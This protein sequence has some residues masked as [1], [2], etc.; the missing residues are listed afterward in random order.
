MQITQENSGVIFNIQKCF[1]FLCLFVLF[2]AFVYPLQI[3]A[4][5]LPA[6]GTIVAGEATINYADRTMNVNQATEKA[7]IHWDTFN[8][9]SSN[10]VNFNQ[11]SSSSVILNQVLQTNPSN[12]QGTINANGIVILINPAGILFGKNSK[13]NVGG[14]IA[15]TMSMESYEEF[16]KGKYSFSRNGSTGKIVNEGT[17]TAT[18]RGMIALLAP[19]VR[20]E[21]IIRANMGLMI[22]GEKV[23]FDF[24]GDELIKVAVDPSTVSALVENKGLVESPG[25]KVYMLASAKTKLVGEVINSGPIVTADSIRKVGGK[26]YLEASHSVHSSKPINA[27]NASGEAV[28]IKSGKSINIERESDVYTT[29]AINFEVNGDNTS[30]ITIGRD[31]TVASTLGSLNFETGTGHK[32]HYRY[33]RIKVISAKRNNTSLDVR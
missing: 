33:K 3:V 21:G 6:G 15:S 5:D 29:G 32:G 28:T 1:N 23:T 9:G 30:N 26:V 22:S 2:S 12:I 31:V 27:P 13:V 10:I 24:D 14:L 17:L 25:G 16:M 7:I 4:N 11:P 8:V 18:D 20:N 19:T